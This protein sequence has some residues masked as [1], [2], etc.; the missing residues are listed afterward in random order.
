MLVPLPQ[1]RAAGP[2]RQAIAATI[3]TL[4][5]SLRQSLTWDQGTELAQHRQFTVDT[6]VAVYFAHP[7]S[8]WERGTNENTNGLLRQYLPAGSVMPSDP[9]TL[10]AIA[11]Q[12]NGRPCRTLGWRTPAEAFSQLMESLV[13]STG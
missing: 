1:G 4:P 13:A 10:Q 11:V 6:G 12:L 3:A 8:P 9:A 7:R 5:T 2:T